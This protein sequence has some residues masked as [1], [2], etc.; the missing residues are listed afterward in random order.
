MRKPLSEFVAKTCRRNKIPTQF[1]AAAIH[2]V[3]SERQHKLQRE[4]R[5]SWAYVTIDGANARDFD[6]AVYSEQRSNTQFLS[7]AI[8]DVASYVPENSPLDLEARE[9]ANSVY[10]PHDV[11]PMLP[12]ELSDN[13][14]SL[15]QDKSRNCIAIDMQIDSEGNVVSFQL[16]AITIISQAR[17]TYSWVEGQGRGQYKHSNVEVQQ[18]L[19]QLW[20]VSKALKK[21]R[22]QRGYLDLFIPECEF[23]FDKNQQVISISPSRQLQSQKLIEEAMLAANQSVSLFLQQHNLR[24]LFR[25]HPKPTKEKIQGLK[26]ILRSYRMQCAENIS[27]VMQLNQLLRALRDKKVPIA[28]ERSLLYCQSRALYDPTSQDHF[29]LGLSSYCHCTSPIRRYADLVVQRQ[30]VAQLTNQRQTELNLHTLALQLNAVEDRTNTTT[31][32]VDQW[33]KLLFVKQLQGKYCM[34]VVTSVV[35]FGV[36]V[37][38]IDLMV[39]GLIHI[40]HL[41]QGRWNYNLHKGIIQ[42]LRSGKSFRIGQMVTVAVRDIDLTRGKLSLTVAQ[43]GNSERRSKKKRVK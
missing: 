9:R 17:L 27:S 19:Q 1:S 31:R 34:A 40:S 13:L 12:T 4:D 26:Q 32:F 8:A 23:E 28:I 2:Q 25:I 22:Q 10:F 21:R 37:E 30:I 16:Q 33:L 6:D 3:N 7:V 42:N 43:G 39:D 18:S 41:G 20:A 14:C 29:G 5:S 38:L 36:F 24:G 15:R 35:Q 11:I